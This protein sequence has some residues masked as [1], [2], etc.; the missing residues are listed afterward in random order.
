MNN[1]S[2]EKIIAAIE[3]GK[4]RGFDEIKEVEG[5]RFFFQYALKKKNGLYNTYIFHIMEKKIEIIEDYGEEEIKEFI[6]ISDALNYF[7]SLGINVQKFSSIKGVL[8][9]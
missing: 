8:P 6:N 7:K 9:F 1:V 3:Q 5:E 4:V 2:I